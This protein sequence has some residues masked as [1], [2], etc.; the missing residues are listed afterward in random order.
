MGYSREEAGD[1]YLYEWLGRLLAQQREA[2]GL[3][4]RELA[5]RVGID[6][7]SVSGYETGRTRVSVVM[8]ARLCNAMGADAGMPVRTIAEDLRRVS[9]S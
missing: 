8:L 3:S 7:S 2:A 6:P 4:Q 5:K 9:G 1:G